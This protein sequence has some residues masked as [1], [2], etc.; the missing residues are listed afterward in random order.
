[1]ILGFTGTREGMN[2]R[3]LLLVKKLLKN[4]RALHHGDCIGADAEVD[5]MC[6]E[7]GIPTM[8]HPPEDATYR[9]WCTDALYVFPKR[10]YLIRNC[11]IVQACDMLIATP[12]TNEEVLRSG[13]WATIR[14]ARDINKKMIIIFPYDEE[15]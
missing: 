13:T 3:Q 8:L 7:V 2:T 9:A 10:P 11:D 15:A 6:K 1:M 5:A 14:Y 12:R 4:I